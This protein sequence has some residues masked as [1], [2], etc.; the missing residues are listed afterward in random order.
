VR[1]ENITKILYPNDSRPAGKQL[2][3]EQQAFFVSCALQDCIRLLL[4]RG[5]IRDFAD[6]FAVQLNDTHPTLAVP[7]LMRLFMDVHGL[8]WDEAWDLTTR[9]I[10]YTNHTLMPEALETWPLPLFQRLL[11]RHTEIIFEINRRFLDEVRARYPGDE[12]RVRRMSLIDE[13]GDR[14]LRMAHLATVASHTVNGVAELHS[15]LLRETVLRDFAEMAPERFTSVTNGVTPRRFLALSNP[16]LSALIT[17]AIG[18]G[19]LTDLERLR[20][21]EPLAED[22]GFRER[23]RAIKRRNKERLAGWL[24]RQ[25]RMVID[26]EPMLDAQCKRIHEYKRQ[27]LNALHVAWLH[28]RIR[29]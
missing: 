9:S 6:V 3:L 26:T 20:E 1:S 28:E 5:T 13:N 21:L 22:A 12:E 18:D 4:H 17:E 29:R 2:R 27:L 16:E 15:R 23:W 19:W 10:S 11:P 8:S 24:A 25:H 14:C 7:E